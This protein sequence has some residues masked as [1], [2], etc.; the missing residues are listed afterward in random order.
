MYIDGIEALFFKNM[1]KDHFNRFCEIMLLIKEEMADIKKKF[2][3]ADV[4]MHQTE[5]S[6]MALNEWLDSVNHAQWS[7]GSLPPSIVTTRDVIVQILNDA[8]ERL[9]R[10]VRFILEYK[11]QITN[12]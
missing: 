6:G 11:S 9:N 12:S 10:D 4:P 7:F 1:D 3:R 5:E 2:P 8:Q